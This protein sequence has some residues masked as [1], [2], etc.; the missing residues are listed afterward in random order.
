MI[1]LQGY[2]CA[3]L[4]TAN[5]PQIV[6]TDSVCT[7]ACQRTTTQRVQVVGKGKLVDEIHGCFACHVGWQLSGKVARS[8]PGVR[9]NDTVQTS[10]GIT[11]SRCP[12]SRSLEKPLGVRSDSAVRVP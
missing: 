12:N 8:D 1:N 6:A 11:G 10:V 3:V 9:F 2:V 7:T 5:R 4:A